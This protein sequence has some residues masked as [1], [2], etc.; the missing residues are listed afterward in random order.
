[1]RLGGVC[2]K[3]KNEWKNPLILLSSIGI[4]SFGDFIYLVA[5]NIIVYQLTGS[6]A[7]VAALWIIGPLTNIILKFWTGSY[8]DYRSKR[9]IMIYTYLFRS[10]FIFLIPFAP[11]IIAIYILL[12]LL[13][14][15]KAFFGPSS[16]TYITMLIPKEQRKRFNSIRSF[17]TSGA[18]IIGPA[19]GGGLIYLTNTDVTL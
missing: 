19:I 17:A 13:S 3:A 10:F 15:A 7:A 14:V 9:S 5:I 1:M 18:F 16:T 4:A 12:V 2:L 6:A 11:N 8:I